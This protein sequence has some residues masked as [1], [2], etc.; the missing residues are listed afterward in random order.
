[1]LEILKCSSERR[2]GIR[3]AI[4]HSGIS[5]K[6]Q[7]IS[8]ANTLQ[9]RCMQAYN[10]TMTQPCVLYPSSLNLTASLSPDYFPSSNHRFHVPSELIPLLAT[11]LTPNPRPGSPD[12]ED[13]PFDIV[14]IVPSLAL[15][16]PARG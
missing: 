6:P 15:S 11:L 2:V 4:Y 14:R 5:R 16:S 8:A 12:S 3:V 9:T 10:P 7:A 1:M 13:I